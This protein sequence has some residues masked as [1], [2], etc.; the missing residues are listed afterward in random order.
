[1]VQ[2]KA[3][4]PPASGPICLVERCRAQST[5]AQRITAAGC[6]GAPQAHRAPCACATAA[7]A[8]EEGARGVCEDVC[9]LS[10]TP[11]TWGH[12]DKADG[13]GQGESLGM[14]GT[15]GMGE[16]MWGEEKGRAWDLKEQLVKA[17]LF[18]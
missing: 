14:E 8:G 12:G 17:E 11:G 3:A 2:G 5:P 13:V 6:F 10:G 15:E 16:E 7:S 9:A 18:F 4:G 1:M